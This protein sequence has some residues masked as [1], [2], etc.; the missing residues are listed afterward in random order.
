[1]AT[2]QASHQAADLSSACRPGGGQRD[3]ASSPWPPAFPAASFGAHPGTLHWTAAGRLAVAA[4]GQLLCADHVVFV[5]RGRSQGPSRAELLGHRV[6]TNA[7]GGLGNPHERS[8]R[9]ASRAVF[10]L[11][12]VASHYQI[13][14][15]R[16]R[17][18]PGAAPHPWGARVP[19][20]HRASRARSGRMPAAPISQVGLPACICMAYAVGTTRGCAKVC[21]AGGEGMILRLPDA[22]RDTCRGTQSVRAR[23]R[24]GYA[25][26]PG[27]RPGGKG[28]VTLAGIR[29]ISRSWAH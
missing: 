13:V 7:R 28:T 1:M 11:Q 29:C 23:H 26:C 22:A 27:A 10:A 15:Q 9:A 17:R 14:N 18:V 19:W 25:T 8:G 16:A 21:R 4:G 6:R 20:W 24:P 5:P 2:W 3:G 12:K